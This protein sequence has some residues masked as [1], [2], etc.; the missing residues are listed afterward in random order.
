MA[1]ILPFLARY[2]ATGAAGLLAGQDQRRQRLIAETLQR[3]QLDRQARLD[4]AAEADRQQRLAAAQRTTAIEDLQLANPGGAIVPRARALEP[5]P[6]LGGPLGPVA[7]RVPTV[8]PNYVT[9][10]DYAT[11]TRNN[12]E[13]RAATAFERAQTAAQAQAERQALI[14]RVQQEAADRRAQMQIEA[15]DRRAAAQNATTLEAARMRA[16]GGSLA[17]Q[18]PTGTVLNPKQTQAARQLRSAFQAEPT[19]KAAND[20]ALGYA[21]VQAGAGDRTPQ[22]D[23]ALLY[24]YMKMLDPGSVVREG[25]YATAAQAAG[26]PAQV[27]NLYNRVLQGYRLT[28]EQRTNMVHQAEAQGEHAHTLVRQ[29]VARHS[30]YARRSGFDPADVVYDPLDTFGGSAARPAGEPPGHAP[31]AAAGGA[32]PSREQRIQQL[33][34]QGVS[35]DEGI[36]ILRREGYQ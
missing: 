27:L 17:S 20:I 21:R 29:T 16:S 34:A 4:A 10:G 35:R 5:V 32:R 18:P 36:A 8:D 25:E 6:M 11:D 26:V 2:A 33:K 9:A 23:I 15:G 1:S 12:A 28:P 31:D 13:T 7:A 24:G 14:Q 22:G 3:Q 19:I 30:D